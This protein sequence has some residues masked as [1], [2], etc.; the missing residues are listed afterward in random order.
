[1]PYIWL[2]T[3]LTPGLPVAI[4]GI[5]PLKPGSK[6]HLAGEKTAM[7]C[8]MATFNLMEWPHMEKQA[9][10]SITKC[11]IPRN[12]ATKKDLII[13]QPSINKVGSGMTN[14]A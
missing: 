1:M 14:K 6:C 8:V 5:D 12:I 7:N 10:R 11:Q 3:S 2:I 4:F 13:S 9:E